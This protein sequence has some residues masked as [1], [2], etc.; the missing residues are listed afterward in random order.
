MVFYEK[1]CPMGRAG[2]RGSGEGRGGDLDDLRRTMGGD[3]R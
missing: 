1:E 2:G 3:D